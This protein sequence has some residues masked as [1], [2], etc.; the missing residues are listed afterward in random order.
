MEGTWAYIWIMQKYLTLRLLKVKR[1]HTVPC[2]LNKCYLRQTKSQYAFDYENHLQISLRLGFKQ[3]YQNHM[4]VFHTWAIENTQILCTVIQRHWDHNGQLLVTKIENKTLDSFK[5]KIA[6]LGCINPIL[7]NFN[8]IAMGIYPCLNNIM[9]LHKRGPRKTNL[10]KDQLWR[11]PKEYS[12]L[13]DSLCIVWQTT[14]TKK[15]RQRE[16]QRV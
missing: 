5:K 1:V 15:E 8:N 13:P 10:L 6:N 9:P 11:D 4:P 16:R 2:L 3:S 12:L 14:P 7:S